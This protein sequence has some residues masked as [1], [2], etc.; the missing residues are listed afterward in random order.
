MPRVILFREEHS[1]RVFVDKVDFVSAHATGTKMGD[2]L[3]AQ[4]IHAVYGGGP[5]VTGL[6]G[7]MGHTMSLTSFARSPA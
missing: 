1:P 7:Y 2:V 4:A 6:K 5:F 3:E